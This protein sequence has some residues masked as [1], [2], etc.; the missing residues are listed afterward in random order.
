[1]G[2]IDKATIEKLKELLNEFLAQPTPIREVVALDGVEL[3][4][5]PVNHV[6][7]FSKFL[8]EKNLDE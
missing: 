6:A 1:M 7:D 3:S 4:A 2:T 8:N 5:E